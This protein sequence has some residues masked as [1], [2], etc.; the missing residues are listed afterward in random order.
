MPWHPEFTYPLARPYPFWW[1]SWLAVIGAL[2]LTVLFSAINLAADGYELRLELT[3]KPNATLDRS[4]WINQAPF[5][6]FD[7]TPA[8]CQPLSLAVQSSFFTNNSGLTYSIEGVYQLD[9]QGKKTVLPSATYL[10]NVLGSCNVSSVVL[11]ISS[12]GRTAD[13]TQGFPWGI[14]A[15]VCRRV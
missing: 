7:K 13:Q 1:F 11:D 9:V 5:S 3:T 12:A 4:L 2:L 6:W 15:V 8:S 14:N 10:N